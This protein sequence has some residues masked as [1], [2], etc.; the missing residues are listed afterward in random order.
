MYLGNF[1]VNLNT[2]I[3]DTISDGY[4]YKYIKA[5]YSIDKQFCSWNKRR[6]LTFC[7]CRKILIILPIKLSER[8][9]RD[10]KRYHLRKFSATYYSPFAIS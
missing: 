3:F 8:A 9:S 10:L 1:F 5:N 7:H 2:I 6:R 4:R